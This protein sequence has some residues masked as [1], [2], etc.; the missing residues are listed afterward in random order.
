MAFAIASPT[1]ARTTFRRCAM[2]R[3]RLRSLGRG[4]EVTDLFLLGGFGVVH[5]GGP[6]ERRVFR[7]AFLHRGTLGRI[8][9]QLSVIQLT[10]SLCWRGYNRGLASA[11]V[12]RDQVFTRFQSRL[13]V[14]AHRKHASERIRR[15]RIGNTRHKHLHFS[16][17][18]RSVATLMLL[19]PY[20]AVEL[21]VFLVSKVGG[22]S[23][24]I[25]FGHIHGVNIIN[26]PL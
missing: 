9:V 5:G 22:R 12:M 7:R 1:I 25:I 4:V 3:P 20:L 17:C 13:L 11:Q 19:F 18:L 15:H 10:R 26:R 23:I 8:D 16:G 21:G 14:T 24:F 6:E 2:R